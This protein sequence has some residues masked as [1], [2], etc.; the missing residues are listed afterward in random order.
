MNRRLWE[1]IRF[2]RER[3]PYYRELYRDVPEESRILSDYPVIEQE[4]FWE[5][6]AHFGEGS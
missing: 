5:A 3:S 1:L 6:N 2:A 4:R